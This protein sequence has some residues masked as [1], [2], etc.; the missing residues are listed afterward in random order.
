MGTKFVLEE[1]LDFLDITPNQLAVA[2]DIRPNTIY[3]MKDNKTKRIEI[4]YLNRIVE[5]LNDFA[6]KKGI[7]KKFTIND[8]MIWEEDKG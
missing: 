6:E 5:T 4:K 2:T 1:T 3:D 8:V 7:N